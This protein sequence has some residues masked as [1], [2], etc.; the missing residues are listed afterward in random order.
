MY[1]NFVVPYVLLKLPFLVFCKMDWE[2]L[3]ETGGKYVS[4]YYSQNYKSHFRK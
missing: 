1:I 4:P 3:H 2:V